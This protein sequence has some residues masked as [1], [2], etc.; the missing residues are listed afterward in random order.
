MTLGLINVE[1]VTG[2]HVVTLT[3]E[4]D[5]STAPELAERIESCFA[6]GS[7]VLVDLTQAEFV[8]S[9]IL[10]ALFKG[11]LFAEGAQGDEFGVVVVPDSLPGRLFEMVGI[12]HRLPTYPTRDAALEALAGQPG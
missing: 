2:I 5:L 9:S 11:N 12:S 7:R 1:D 8:D 4:H 6:S 10:A 3:G